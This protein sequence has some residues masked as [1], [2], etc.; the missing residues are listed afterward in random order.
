M[1]AE[2]SKGN[3]TPHFFGRSMAFCAFGIR[4]CAKVLTQLQAILL[5]SI[6]FDANNTIFLAP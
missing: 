6:L 5:S 3:W 2:I 1:V 4:I